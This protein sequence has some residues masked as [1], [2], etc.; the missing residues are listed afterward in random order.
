M[1]G[2]GF[3][4]GLP[5]ELE[6]DE[7]LGGDNGDED[8]A[9]AAQLVALRVVQELEG[10]PQA[11]GAPQQDEEEAQRVEVV[12]RRHPQHKFQ[13]EGVQLCERKRRII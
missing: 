9:L 11:D 4:D 1:L 5:A 13:V 2:K 8:P 3:S 10:L 7:Q 12:L 6:T